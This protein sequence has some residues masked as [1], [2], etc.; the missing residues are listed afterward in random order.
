MFDI[1]ELENEETKEKLIKSTENCSDLIY[2]NV[3]STE[4]FGKKI[5]Y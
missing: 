2:S 1:V 4:N 3:K 5:K